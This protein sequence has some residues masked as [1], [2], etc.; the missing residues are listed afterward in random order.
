[1]TVESVVAVTPASSRTSTRTV[2]GC[3]RPTVATGDQLCWYPNGRRFTPLAAAQLASARTSSSLPGTAVH[4]LPVTMVLSQLL[5]TAWVSLIP[6]G[7]F[8][9]SSGSRVTAA[10]R[11]MGEKMT[12]AAARAESFPK[13]LRVTS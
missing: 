4:I 12:V 5:N 9:M 6:S 2:R 13:F 11:P 7:K 3:G 1:M 10:A 8:D